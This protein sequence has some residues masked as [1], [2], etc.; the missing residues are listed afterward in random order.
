[1]F[2]SL[3]IMAMVRERSDLFDLFLKCTWIVWRKRFFSIATI[4]TTTTNIENS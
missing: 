4:T 1:M 3:K 2:D